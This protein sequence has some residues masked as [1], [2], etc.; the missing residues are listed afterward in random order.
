[1]RT[2]RGDKIAHNFGQSAVLKAFVRVRASPALQIWHIDIDRIPPDSLVKAF[3]CEGGGNFQRWRG[4]GRVTKDPRGERRRINDDRRLTRFLSQ[5]RIRLTRM[6]SVPFLPDRGPSS[7]CLCLLACL[8]ENKA[9]RR[10][11]SDGSNEGLPHLLVAGIASAA[12]EKEEA[13]VR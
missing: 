9:F 11:I 7:F 2:D 6:F 12:L 5:T 8:R 1:V 3:V 13:S 10:A 4:A